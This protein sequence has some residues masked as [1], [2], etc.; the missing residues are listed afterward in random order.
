MNKCLL[1]F[2]YQRCGLLARSTNLGLFRGGVAGVNYH[3]GKVVLD[4]ILAAKTARY[5]SAA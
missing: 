2:A 3:D 4:V 5:G 1:Q